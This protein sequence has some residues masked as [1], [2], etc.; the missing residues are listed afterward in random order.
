MEI[1]D[2]SS[3]I[4]VNQYLGFIYALVIGILLGIDHEFKK[5]EKHQANT[6]GLKSFLFVS[7]LGAL[8][9]FLSL[10]VLENTLFYFVFF[11][12]IVLVLL[13]FL[14]LNFIKTKTFSANV[15]YSLIMTFILGSLCV[16]GYTEV[17]I[18]FTLMTTI[19]TSLNKTA[20]NIFKKI[21]A[22]EISSTIKFI[23]TAIIVLPFLPNKDYTLEAFPSLYN[24]L[25][26]YDLIGSSSFSFT[27]INP[28][29][30][31]LLVIVISF[32][33]FV[34]YLL[35][36]LFGKRGLLASSF[37]RGLVSSTNVITGFSSQTKH[38][39]FNFHLAAFGVVVAT[40]AMIFRGF[41]DVLFINS[42]MLRYLFFPFILGI[43]ACALIAFLLYHKIL[44]KTNFKLPDVKSPFS[45]K[46]L[47]YL[48]IVFFVVMV[49][50]RLLWIIMG[51]SGLYIVSFA[52]G[53]LSFNAVTLSLANLAISGEITPIAATFSVFLALI[54]NLMFKGII[55]YSFG[56]KE[57]YATL[58]NMLFLVILF[59]CAIGFM[60]LK[61]F[62][63]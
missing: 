44:K 51:Q 46:R 10:R 27:V 58:V 33:S 13:T 48:S 5:K 39:G 23:I 63:L 3:F 36:K 4:N 32:V 24:L 19:I 57:K 21:N 41:F 60:V 31:W 56:E 25:I 37:F 30:I 17:A 14:T 8:A 15:E 29:R 43:L 26:D 1:F 53:L 45:M 47:F 11:V 2:L 28:H 12:L 50:S 16:F 18:V 34:G 42:K 62:L 49:A 35:M 9:A 61:F 7:L 6:P 55:V 40:G 59:A 54:S 20:T 38:K 52:S 22:K